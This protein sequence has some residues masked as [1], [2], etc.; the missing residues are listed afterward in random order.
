MQPAISVETAIGLGL[1]ELVIAVLDTNDGRASAISLARRGGGASISENAIFASTGIL[2]ND[3]AAAPG[4]ATGQ[5]FLLTAALGIE[6]NIFWCSRQAITLDGKVMHFLDTQDHRQR[7]PYL[8]RKFPSA[9]SG[10]A[11]RIRR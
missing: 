9:R 3:P 8:L 2:A 1:R 10:S 6:D 5:R 4:K 7:H 11:W